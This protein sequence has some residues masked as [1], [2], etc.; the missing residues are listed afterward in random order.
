MTIGRAGGEILAEVDLADAEAARKRCRDRLVVDERLLLRDERLGVQQVALV[1]VDH[2]LAYRLAI[3]QLAVAIVDDL[4]QVGRRLQRLEL[5]DVVGRRQF[6]QQVA[7][8][9]V[10]AGFEMQRRY[11]AGDLGAEAGPVDG[12]E[13]A[14][15]FQLRLPVLRGGDRC[16]DGLRRVGERGHH[17]AD[18]RGFERLKAEDAPQDHPGEDQHDEHA[19]QHRQLFPSRMSVPARSL[20]AMDRSVGGQR[21]N[22][23]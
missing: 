12:A 4:G 9:D 8:L 19:L 5:G 21:T 20:A 23:E 18:H 1:G 15:R 13:A 16:R 10:G 17:L 14:D 6:Q 7:L 3:D 2:L 11:Q 22:G